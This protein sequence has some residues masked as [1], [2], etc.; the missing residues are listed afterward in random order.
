MKWATCYMKQRGK[1]DDFCNIIVFLLTEIQNVINR[2]DY[3]KLKYT[4]Q[5]IKYQTQCKIQNAK[6]N[7][8]YKI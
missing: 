4:I 2:T 8:K 1:W 6:Y 5:V 7:I 3:N